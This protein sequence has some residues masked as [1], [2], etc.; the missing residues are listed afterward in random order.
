LIKRKGEGWDDE[1][2]ELAKMK[3]EKWLKKLRSL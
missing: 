3:V 1:E 2:L